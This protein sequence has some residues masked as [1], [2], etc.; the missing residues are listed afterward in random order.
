MNT[1]Y[2]PKG[3]AAEYG[4]Y[5]VNIYTGCPHRCYYCFAPQVLHRDREAFHS[6]VEPR[7]GIVAE[8]RRKLERE[9]ITG[10]LVHLCFTCDPYP[11][12]RDT[13]T[14]REVIKALKE[15]GNH[16]QILTKGDGSR[17][18]DLL[19][20][21][22]WYGVTI[23]CDDPMAETAEPGAV[24]PASRLYDL[25]TAKRLGIKTWVSFEP[26][27]DPAAVLDCIKGCAYFIDRVKIGK[28]N[29]HPSDIDWVRFGRE[30][31]AACKEMGLDY[32]IKDS[33]RAE[34]EK[35]AG[36]P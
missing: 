3:A 1:I 34:M 22:D 19:D 5:A 23:S 14:T 31:V 15:Y 9:K 24:S 26:I 11:T 32:Y 7:K 16:V 36:K 33:L 13:T 21:E 29:Y 27:L 20:G 12:G 18:F 6:C 10:K 30:T 25:E 2:K 8:L 28:L 17:D 4:D 35:E